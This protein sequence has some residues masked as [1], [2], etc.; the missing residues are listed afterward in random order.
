MDIRFKDDF[1]GKPRGLTPEM[2]EQYAKD[3]FGA[4]MEQLGFNAYKRPLWYKLI[5]DEVLLAFGLSPSVSGTYELRC[6]RMQNPLTRLSP[7]FYVM[8]R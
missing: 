3:L 7:L 8:L 1:T 5:R 2:R 6:R 4:E